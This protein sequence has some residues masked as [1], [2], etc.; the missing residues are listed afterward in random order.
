LRPVAANSAYTYVPAD[1]GWIAVGDACASH[2]PLCGWGVERALSNG[3]LLADALD[4][5][6]AGDGGPALAAFQQHCA[7]QYAAYL[8][9]L[10]ERYALER[11]W[12][13]A[14]FWMRRHRPDAGIAASP[15][16]QSVRVN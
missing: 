9:G 3:I 8:A 2:D 6:L 12:P 1:S 10:R 16:E 14:P 5:Y 11:R 15:N 7:N 13:D 4:R